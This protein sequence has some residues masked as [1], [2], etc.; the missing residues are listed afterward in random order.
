MKNEES[1]FASTCKFI[2]G[3]AAIDQLPGNFEISECAFVGKSNVG[4]SS[5]INSI[6]GM[7]CA[8]VSKQPGRTQQINFF[9]L[10]DKIILVDLPGYGYA[11]VSKQMRIEWD[12]LILHYL[13]NRKNL[14]RVYLLIDSRRGIKD[15]DNQV[16]EIFDSFGIS[17]QIVLT[18]ADKIE[19]QDQL[20]NDIAN[21]LKNHAAAFPKVIITS[22]K[23]KEGIQKL[24]Q[25]I[26]EFC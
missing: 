6:T 4:K 19:N 3:A 5:L 14:K 13:K 24:R 8:R 26:Y 17:Y 18:K 7:N 23:S 25:S 20:L 16:M 11:A 21:E 22:S 9:S 12:Q 15:N 2:A 10:A 1:L